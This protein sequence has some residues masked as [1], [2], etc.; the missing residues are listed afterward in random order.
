MYINDQEHTAES[1]LQKLRK[2]NRAENQQKLDNLGNLYDSPVNDLLGLPRIDKNDDYVTDDRIDAVQAATPMSMQKVDLSKLLNPNQAPPTSAEIVKKI[3][4]SSTIP[5]L[6]SQSTSEQSSVDSTG[7]EVPR[8]E[9]RD[10][11]FEE[12]NKTAAANRFSAMMNDITSKLGNTISQSGKIS[13]DERKNT[14]ENVNQGLIK[15]ADQPLVDLQNKRA[16]FLQLMKETSERDA[17]DPNSATS[18]A[19]RDLMAE[20]GSPVADTAT[21]AELEPTLTLTKEKYRIK[22][23]RQDRMDQRAEKALARKELLEAK[24]SAMSDK[25][26][27]EAMRVL[28]KRREKFDKDPALERYKTLK[29]AANRLQDA[30]LNGTQMEKGAAAALY[31]KVVQ[32]DNSAIRESDIQFIMGKFGLTKEAA[33]N[34]ITKLITGDTLTKKE[35]QV[36]REVALRQ[37]S[38]EFGQLKA[39]EERLID[40]YG[41]SKGLDSDTISL[42]KTTDIDPNDQ[43]IVDRQEIKNSYYKQYKKILTDEQADAQLE[44]MKKKKEA[45]SEE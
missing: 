19:A 35:A 21:A 7:T 18:K 3:T 39:K 12:A 42:Y 22:T 23:D 33:S 4:Q 24:I 43:K 17:R 37:L 1:W 16:S 20:F 2:L 28:E 8:K 10:T 9:L 26:K 29:E 6:K 44:Y 36:A 5:Q 31:G 27:Q 40:Q 15:S 11:E 45:E 25:G 38:R 34:S 13:D 32:Y 41:R 14:F 30:I